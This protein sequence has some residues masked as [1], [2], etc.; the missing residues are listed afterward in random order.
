MMTHVRCMCARAFRRVPCVCA[1]C[2]ETG[3]SFARWSV[4]LEDV[5]VGPCGGEVT[6]RVT[7]YVFRPS[8]RVRGLCGKS[9][10]LLFVKILQFLRQRFDEN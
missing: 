1:W 9:P 4:R 7:V 2:R 3:I 5:C 10:Q 8:R 6:E